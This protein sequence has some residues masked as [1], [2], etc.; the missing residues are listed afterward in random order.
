MKKQHDQHGM[1]D[2]ATL[3]GA[4]A[5]ATTGLVAGPPGVIAGGAI[6]TAIGYLAGAILE[7]EDDKR[8][9]KE[10]ALDEEIGVTSGDI[11]A[12]EAARKGLEKREQRL[13][14]QRGHA[15]AR[16]RALER[17]LEKKA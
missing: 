7:D 14:T 13:R 11:G 17:S 5:G 1:L 8:E 15:V 10:E 4:V 9:A 6:G 3:A 2:A 12:A 16:E